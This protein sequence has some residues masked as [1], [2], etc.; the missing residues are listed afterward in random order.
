M[1]GASVVTSPGDGSAIEIVASAP[2]RSRPAGCCRVSR[3]LFSLSRP[4]VVAAASGL[5]VSR[6]ALQESGFSRDLGTIKAHVDLATLRLCPGS[7]VDD[8]LRH[9]HADLLYRVQARGGGEALGS[10]W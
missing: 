1:C 3:S 8:E 4:G 6:V 2:S 9:A 5:L 7:F 10:K